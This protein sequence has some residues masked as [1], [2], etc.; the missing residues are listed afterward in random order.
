MRDA[1]SG[2]CS[3]GWKTCLPMH[4]APAN[5]FVMRIGSLRGAAGRGA[6][7]GGS[8]RREARFPSDSRRAQNAQNLKLE[9]FTHQFNFS[10]RY[11]RS[12]VPG[13]SGR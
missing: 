5:F 4:A 6:R 1:F 8:E 9:Y 11:E 7:G 13:A 12:V 10:E 2:V 3:H